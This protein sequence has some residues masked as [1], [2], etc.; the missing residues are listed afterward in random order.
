MG[1]LYS[2]VDRLAKAMK[3][4]TEKIDFDP[5]LLPPEVV[6]YLIF[7]YELDL[8]DGYPVEAS[9]ILLIQDARFI[10]NSFVEGPFRYFP[11]TLN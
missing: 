3:H 10:A 8:A 11:T 9:S 7:T 6:Q 2:D 4:H 1:V 5:F